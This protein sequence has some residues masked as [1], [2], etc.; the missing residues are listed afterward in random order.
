M[1]KT[2]EER[3]L[4]K[5]YVDPETGCWIWT[6]SRYKGGYGQIGARSIRKSNFAAS[7]VAWMLYRGPIPKG[8]GV[9]HKCDNPSCANV[10]H[11]FLG[12]QKANVQDMI[13]KNR[14]G[15]CYPGE[16]N[17]QAKLSREQ[18]LE[19]RRIAANDEKIS[20]TKIAKQFGVSRR[21]IGFII[22]RQRWAHI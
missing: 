17:P 16:R 1:R 13:S 8:M 5:V 11:L 15:I 19:I 3:F 4:S 21:T 12:D 22:S 7:Q 6:G 18:V 2:L 9:L 20:H 10:D 14:N